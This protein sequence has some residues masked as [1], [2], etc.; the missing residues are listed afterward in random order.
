MLTGL[1]SEE[2]ELSV[3]DNKS[4]ESFETAA[5]IK[6]C[7]CQKCPEISDVSN[8]CRHLN[9]WKDFEKGVDKNIC[10]VHLILNILSR[11]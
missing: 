11:C 7:E 6:S 4:V 9:N 2:G 10:P 3:Q 1:E 5:E 8:C